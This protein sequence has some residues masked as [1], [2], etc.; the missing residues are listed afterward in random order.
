MSFRPRAP[1]GGGISLCLGRPNP[2]DQG[3]IPRFARND[4]PFQS[5]EESALVRFGRE[6]RSQSAVGTEVHSP[7]ERDGIG[8]SISQGGSGEGS[9]PHSGTVQTGLRFR[10]TPTW[11]ADIDARARTQ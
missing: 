11:L 2:N 7:D 9:L 4:S 8:A 10:F 5:S 3:E 6:S 1:R